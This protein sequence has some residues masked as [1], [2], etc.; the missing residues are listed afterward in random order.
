[1]RSLEKMNFFNIDR[2]YVAIQKTLESYQKELFSKFDFIQGEQVK[3]LESTLS[4]YTNSECV[5]VGN[6]TDALYIAL[7]SLDLQ[8]EDEVI[9]PTFTWVST[10]EVVKQARAK[11]VF[12]DVDI[13][14]FNIDLEDL[15]TKITKN[16]RAIISVSLFG[17]VSNLDGIKQI[18]KDKE[19]ILI[20]DAAQ[21]FGAKHNE[22]VSCSIADIST[23][24]FF[25]T[26]PLGCFGDGGAVFTNNKSFID[27]IKV[28]PKHGQ[29]NRYNYIRWG[30]NSRLDT[31]QACVLLSKLKV[32][33]KEL[34]SRQKNAAIYF[35]EL[36]SNNLIQLPY[37]E[38]NNVSVYAIFTLKLNDPEMRESFKKHMTDHG[39]PVGFYYPSLHNSQPYLSNE[40]YTNSEILEKSVVSI[41]FDAYFRE[42]ELSNIS[43]IINKF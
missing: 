41:P 37:I 38:S 19:I 8:P 24:S 32:F 3:L 28:I 35:E 21:S 13:D 43:K 11:L 16:T 39:I 15:K 7:L 29:T 18:I 40:K 14:T 25:P 33:E 42:D 34:S 27:A 9:V 31:Y 23:T 17:Q 22:K 30:I 6:G 26:K 4:D 10:A 12:C 1:V 36:A 2:Q 5:T 20:E